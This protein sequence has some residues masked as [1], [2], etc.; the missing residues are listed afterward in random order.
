MSLQEK[1][2][3]WKTA[4]HISLRRWCQSSAG[5][6]WKLV[7]HLHGRHHRL[8]AAGMWSHGNL[9]QM[10]QEDERVPHLQAVRSAGR[11]CLQVLRNSERWSGPRACTRPPPPPEPWVCRRGWTAV[12]DVSQGLMLQRGAS[13]LPVFGTRLLPL[14]YHGLSPLPSSFTNSC[15]GPTPPPWRTVI[16]CTG[17]LTLSLSGLLNTQQKAPA[18]T[19]YSLFSV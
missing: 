10:W 1:H 18:I 13:N 12:H 8:R 9:H 17:T 16:S 4:S 11:A 5:G 15:S 3:N 19:F 14:A 2:C 7:S 6:R